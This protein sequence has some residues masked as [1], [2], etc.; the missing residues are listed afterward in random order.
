V[1]D[2]EIFSTV[3]RNVPL[4][5][6]EQKFQ[7]LSKVEATSTGKLFD[8]LPRNNVVAEQRSDIFYVAY[9][10]DPE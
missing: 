4:L 8:S 1:T 10:C 9:C 5:L 7:L 2:H 3:I 6:H